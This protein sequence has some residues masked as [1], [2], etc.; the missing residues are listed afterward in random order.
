MSLDRLSI[1]D[2]TLREGEQFYNANFSQKDKIKIATQLSDF[3]VEYIELTSPCVS[4]QS[5]EDCQVISRMGLKSKILTH[6]RC[7]KEDVI[8]AIDT[9]V[10]GIN[11]FSRI[12]LSHDRYGLGPQMSQTLEKI[13]DVL[14]FARENAPEL[15]IRFSLEDAFRTRIEDLIVIYGAVGDSGLVDRLGVADTVGYALPRDVE[16]VIKLL[17]V[18]TGMDIEF[19][20][21]N[22]TGSAVVNSYTAFEAGATHI[23]TTVLGIGE[24]NGITSLAGFIARLY[25]F[26]AEMVKKKYNLGN[27]KHLH[28]TVA[29]ILGIGIPWDHPIVGKSAFVH[30]AGV[31]TKAVILNPKSYEIIDPS[32]FNASRTIMVAHKLTGWNAVKDR[33]QK[34]G[35]SFEDDDI[36]KITLKIKNISDGRNIDLKEVDEILRKSCDLI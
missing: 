9:G 24:R 1:V 11:L 6:I 5:K 3:G 14:S 34:I 32:D 35:L 23:D 20:C 13:L 18:L 28:E 31:H 17:H 25:S 10:A 22:D 33:A 16:R 4:S 26:E 2:T 12:S 30:K 21:H 19:H 8:T 36:K 29:R 15:E 7:I 27:L